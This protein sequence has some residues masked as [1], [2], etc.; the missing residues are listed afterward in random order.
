MLRILGEK[1]FCLEGKT[2][3]WT[4]FHKIDGG[5]HIR[6][7]LLKWHGFWSAGPTGYLRVRCGCSCK[8]PSLRRKNHSTDRPEEGEEILIAIA[9]GKGRRRQKRC[10]SQVRT[11]AD[12]ADENERS[13]R[14]PQV[15]VTRIFLFHPPAG[16]GSFEFPPRPASLM[17]VPR[18]YVLGNTVSA[19]MCA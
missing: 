2:S 14:W 1:H 6:H 10:G 15:S 12:I 13:E 16:S 11:N 17:D 3:V 18:H 4:T 5:A 9:K 19:S 7:H 8:E